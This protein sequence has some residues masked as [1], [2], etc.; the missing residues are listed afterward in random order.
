MRE[1]ANAEC[2]RS[3]DVLRVRRVDEDLA[4]A[5]PEEGVVPGVTQAYVA[6]LTQV[7][8]SFVQVLPPFVVL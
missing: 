4:D 8:G 5:A 3:V 7:S 1:P 6:L 2:G